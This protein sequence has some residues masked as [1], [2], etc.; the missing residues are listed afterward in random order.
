MI[1]PRRRAKP[2]ATSRRLWPGRPR[3]IGYLPPA[4]GSPRN[5]FGVLQTRALVEG[6]R[7]LGWFDG[8]NVTIDHRFSG[9][10]RERIRT[11]ATELVA[12][13]PDVIMSLADVVRVKYY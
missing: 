5:V 12:S 13:N 3:R 8:R 9:D 10:D 6:L 1:R 4:T 2:C 7:E 11:N